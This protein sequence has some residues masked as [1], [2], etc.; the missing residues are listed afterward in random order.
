MLITDD[1][2][3]KVKT[4]LFLSIVTIVTGQK[5]AEVFGFQ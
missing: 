4:K 5:K 2:C 1:K 3:L